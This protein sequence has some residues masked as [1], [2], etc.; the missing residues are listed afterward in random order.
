MARTNKAPE[1]KS[2]YEK[3][4]RD[5]VNG[6]EKTDKMIGYMSSFKAMD[7]TGDLLKNQMKYAQTISGVSQAKQASSMVDMAG[8][9]RKGSEGLSG[10]L[11]VYSNV[12]K[13]NAIAELLVKGDKNIGKAL[14]TQLTSDKYAEIEAV[15]ADHKKMKG[16]VD[17]EWLK[18]AS[19][20]GEDIHSDLENTIKKNMKEHPE[21]LSY[22]SESNSTL[23]RN[24]LTDK[25]SA[26][27]VDTNK[28]N[29][30]LSAYGAEAEKGLHEDY[31][32]LSNSIANT[33][34][35]KS[36][37]GDRYQ[38]AVNEYSKRHVG[39]YTNTR[40]DVTDR[41]HQQITNEDYRAEKKEVSNYN[42]AEA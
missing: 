37:Q 28:G 10:L 2:P 7:V 40:A 22:A 5:N 1:Q 27:G 21:G 4:T 26:L 19:E 9:L 36:F 38:S 24:A 23:L 15:V 41:E 33:E 3:F 6:A 32:N 8:I 29:D 30:I 25:L 18:S 16:Y 20:G 14:V 39:D 13:N 11:S 12:S 17:V 31:N 34:A 35:L 42:R